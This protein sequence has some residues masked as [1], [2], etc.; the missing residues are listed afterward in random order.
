M[1]TKVFLVRWE[2]RM[3]ACGYCLHKLIFLEITLRYSV[4]PQTQANQFGYGVR[5]APGKE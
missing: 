2:V 5:L 3:D 4:N 1:K